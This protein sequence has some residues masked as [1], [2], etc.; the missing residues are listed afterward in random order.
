M[1][2]SLSRAVAATLLALIGGGGHAF[3]QYPSGYGGYGW[4]GWGGATAPGHTAAGMGAFAAGAGQAAANVGQRNVENSQARSTNAQTAMAVNNYVWECNQRNN[5][6]Y[7]QR[8]AAEQQRNVDVWNTVRQRVLNNPSEMDIAD[9]DTLNAIY[10]EITSPKVYGQALAMAQKTLAGPMVRK[11]PFN[12]A[13]GGFTYALGELTERESVPSV[14]SNPAFDDQRRAARSIA[15]ELKKEATA[16][17]VP[18]P[19]TLR[20][21]RATLDGIKA[22][23]E[24]ITQPETDERLDGEKYLKALYGLSRMLESPAYDVYLAAAGQEP[25]VPI[26]DVLVF[27]HAFNL[28]FGPS[29][30]P[31]TREIY[32]QLYGILSQL[33]QQLNPPQDEIM[34]ASNNGPQRDSRPMNFYANMG[35]Q[36]LAGPNG[37]PPPSPGAAQP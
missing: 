11:I 15:A 22:T 6:L 1:T 27:M 34:A 29:K 33:R 2:H 14:F 17:N 9:G 32:S 8:K 5:A 7:W 28:R 12:Y 21:F 4:H 25:T 3:A 24:K 20:K 30:D 26:C 13:A 23:L 35:Y 16:N 36:H 37:P 19:E 10:D 18:R 31:E